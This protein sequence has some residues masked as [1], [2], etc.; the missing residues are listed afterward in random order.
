[1]RV[2]ARTGALL[3][4]ALVEAGV[5]VVACAAVGALCGVDFPDADEAWRAR[6]VQ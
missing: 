1:M 5:G 4:A 6:R 3:K 2:L